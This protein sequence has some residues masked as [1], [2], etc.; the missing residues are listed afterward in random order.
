MSCLS[1]RSPKAVTSR[2]RDHQ[3]DN[4]VIFGTGSLAE[5]MHFYLERD[6]HYLPP[7]YSCRR[8][9][10]AAPRPSRMPP[11]EESG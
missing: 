4:V 11:S 9:R 6:S 5:L 2:Q 3:R 10:V 1:R 8:A 7:G